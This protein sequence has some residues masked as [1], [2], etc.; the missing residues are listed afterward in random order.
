MNGMQ[1]FLIISGVA[2]VAL[3]IALIGYF[4]EKKRGE[5][6][7]ATAAELGLSFQKED[8][9]GSLI[10]NLSNFKLFGR[11]RRQRARNVI[12]ADTDQLSLKIFDYH[13]I[14]GHGKSRK[15][16]RQSVVAINVPGLNVPAFAARPENFFDGIGSMLGRQDIDFDDDPVFSKSFVLQGPSES[17]IRTAFTRTVRQFFVAKKPCAAEGAGPSLIYYQPNRRVSPERIRE[18]LEIGVQLS[19][20]FDV[21]S[22]QLQTP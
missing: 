12:E 19:T 4:N 7:Q 1:L 22:S 18:Y 14:T 21:E 10:C 11:G 8:L 5:A 17:D 9:G 20:L 13:F 16:H 3:C 15:H 2:G 6:I